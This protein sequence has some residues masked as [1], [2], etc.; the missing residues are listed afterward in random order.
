MTG[1]DH[2]AEPDPTAGVDALV[3]EIAPGVRPPAVRRCDAIMVAGPWLAGVSAVA[4]ALADR[5]PQWRV[6]EATDLMP[7][8]VPT[9]VVFVVSA[10]AALTD[11][12]CVLL[13]AAA[14]HTDV[15]IGVVSKIDVH[16]QWREMQEVARETLADYAPRYRDVAWVGA[17][18]APERGEPRVDDLVAELSKQLGDN[19]VQRRNRLRSWE[20]QLRT[21]ADRVDRDARAEGR[22]ARVALLQEQRD[23]VVR[24]RRMSKSERVIALRSRI[25]QA[26]VQLSYFARKRCA[27]VRG[28][29][30]E[31]AAGMTRRRL[32]EFEGNVR[33]RLEEVVTEV[34]EGVAEHL[35]DVAHELGL[36]GDAAAATATPPVPQFEI[37][38]PALAS[39]RLETQLMTLLGVGFGLGVALTLSRLFA[40]LA[41]GLTAAGAA[42]C[43]VVGVAVTV[44]VVRIRG[45]LRDRAVLDRWVGEATAALRSA[46]QELVALR[47]VAAESALTAELAERN[48]TEAARAADRIAALDREL[49]EHAAATARAAAVRDRQLPTLQRALA[50]VRSELGGS[51]RLDA[52]EATLGP[53]DELGGS[54]RLDAGEATLG[55][56]DELGESGS[57]ETARTAAD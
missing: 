32:P 17:A 31:D 56:P 48:E 55:P 14:A 4:S 57:P 9:A 3:A 34:D 1:A 38:A 21:D 51:A 10:A 6:V 42:L 2:L 28:E 41:P 52:G 7:G 39:R 30:A 24:Q 53:P 25:S 45:L 37:G 18:A 22:R 54:A 16:R 20:F 12:D 33:R 8:E 19:D 47:V 44:W 5:L 40:H 35:A 49:R 11:S 27:S 29:L 46:L 36:S 26:R 43:V 13:D 23:E 50:A 15:V